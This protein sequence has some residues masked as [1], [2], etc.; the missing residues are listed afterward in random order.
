MEFLMQPIRG[1]TSLE[2]VRES[3]VPPSASAEPPYA[4]GGSETRDGLGLEDRLANKGGAVKQ[5]TPGGKVLEQVDNALEALA[6][7]ADNDSVSRTSNQLNGLLAPAKM[8]EMGQPSMSTE[9][10][11]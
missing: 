8:K 4:R 3:L 2:E 7:L 6:D 1:S 9:K 11:P 5:A 10:A